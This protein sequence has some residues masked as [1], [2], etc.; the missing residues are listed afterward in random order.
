[1]FLC[2]ALEHS[3][4]RSVICFAIPTR[5]RRWSTPLDSEVTLLAVAARGEFV[6]SQLAVAVL[7]ERGEGL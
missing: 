1:M 7:V 3:V 6:A 4:S 2:A 5:R